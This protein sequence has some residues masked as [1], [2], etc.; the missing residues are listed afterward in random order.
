M[1]RNTNWK[2][3]EFFFVENKGILIG[4]YYLNDQRELKE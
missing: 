4:N 3:L 2:L 1:R